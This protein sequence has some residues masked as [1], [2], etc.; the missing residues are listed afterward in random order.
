M[1]IINKVRKTPLSSSLQYN[2]PNKKVKA[3]WSFASFYLGA[4][5]VVGMAGVA[6]G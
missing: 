6:G 1:D 4:C 2:G 3:V 5:E